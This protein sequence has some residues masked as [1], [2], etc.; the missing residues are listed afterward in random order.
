MKKITLLCLALFG[1]GN[2][3]I[4][5]QWDWMV[6]TQSVPQSEFGSSI[7]P[8]ATVSDVQGNI[9]MDF[10]SYDTSITIGNQTFSGGSWLGR[11]FLVKLNNAGVVQWIRDNDADDT[12]IATAL[13]TDATGN[14]YNGG[15]FT[16]N[17]DYQGYTFTGGESN[18]RNAF[19]SKMD[20]TGAT[21]WAKQMSITGNPDNI[22]EYIN[23]FIRTYDVATDAAGNVF[24]CGQMRGVNGIFGD[25]IVPVQ[26]EAD[27]FLAKYDNNGNVLWVKSIEEYGYQGNNHLA[28][29]SAGNVYITGSHAGDGTIVLN[30]TVMGGSTIS[31]TYVAKYSPTGDIVWVQTHGGST[32]QDIYC[33]NVA[34]DSNDNIYTVGYMNYGSIVFGD[35]TLT[36]N[37]GQNHGYI[38][39]YNSAGAALWANT[40]GTYQS[41]F[42]D[43]VTGSNGDVYVTGNFLSSQI[44]FGQTTLTNQGVVNGFVAKMDATGNYQWARQTGGNWNNEWYIALNEQTNSIFTTGTYNSLSLG[45]QTYTPETPGEIYLARL[46][47]VTLNTADFNTSKQNVY[48]NPAK[49]LINIT[50][51]DNGPFTITDITGRTVAQGQMQV[52]VINV[53]QLPSGM[54]LLN[55]NNATTKFIKE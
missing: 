34:V 24:V 22:D 32:T 15:E 5:Q 35:V 10:I 8:S 43:V 27:T 25:I 19:V 26:G 40:T 33:Y 14:I 12:V 20:D 31:L 36:A 49:D 48:P 46:S 39:K 44:A 3:L 52:N 51:I 42:R 16:G 50:G 41:D 11:N 6:S 18:I 2:T 37:A 1:F 17:Y 54:Y 47:T 28:C 13:A 29:D 30:G 23:R 9:Y 38:V 53:S 45:G 55:V 4:A 7:Y 21:L